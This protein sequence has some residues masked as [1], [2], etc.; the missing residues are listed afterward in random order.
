LGQPKPGGGGPPYVNIKLL[1]KLFQLGR[2]V[3]IFPP[4]LVDSPVDERFPCPYPKLDDELVTSLHTES[5][6]I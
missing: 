1:L 3:R 2:I 5:C 4:P 6:G